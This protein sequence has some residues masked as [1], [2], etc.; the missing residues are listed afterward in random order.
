MKKWM[1]YT[2]VA[3]MILISQFVIAYPKAAAQAVVTFAGL[4]LPNTFKQIQTF[5]SGIQLP[6]S[7]SGSIQIQAAATTASYTFTLPSTSPQPNQILAAG[8]SPGSFQWT[9]SCG[10]FQAAGDLS[11]NGT[12][13]TVVGLNGLDFDQTSTPQDGYVLKYSAAKNTYSWQPE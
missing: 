5:N 6:G 4:E 12:S 10:G 2:V 11:G 7:Q 1:K 8:L 13:Q 9:A 3:T